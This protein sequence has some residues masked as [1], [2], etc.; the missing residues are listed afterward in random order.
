MP[1][2][3]SSFLLVVRPGAPSSILAA[4]VAMPFTS[5]ASAAFWVGG[6]HD[7]RH[8]DFQMVAAQRSLQESLCR[9]VR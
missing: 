5:L 2:D 7:H 6:L 4:F 3:T 8:G 9:R 1:G